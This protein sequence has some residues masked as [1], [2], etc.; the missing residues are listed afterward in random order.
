MNFVTL[1]ANTYNMGDVPIPIDPKDLISKAIKDRRISRD[2]VIIDIIKGDIRLYVTYLYWK[3]GSFKRSDYY[4]LFGNKVTDEDAREAFRALFSW[5]YTIDAGIFTDL[6][7]KNKHYKTLL[8]YLRDKRERCRRLEEV[9]TD[10]ETVLYYMF[11][12][13][14]APALHKFIYKSPVYLLLAGIHGLIDVSQYYQDKLLY[15]KE[16]K[17]YYQNSAITIEDISKALT[18]INIAKI[19]T[20]FKGLNQLPKFK[21]LKE[22]PKFTTHTSI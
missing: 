6:C 7:L 21:G 10:P 22:L 14:N 11:Y 9:L 16:V 19:K 1:L 17:E 12:V 8:C 13:Y 2:S 3:T 5:K 18:N 20:Q 4:M 15:S